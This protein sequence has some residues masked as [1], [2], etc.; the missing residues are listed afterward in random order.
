MLYFS[1]SAHFNQ[2]KTFE[3]L[4]KQTYLTKEYFNRLVEWLFYLILFLIRAEQGHIWLTIFENVSNFLSKRT[5]NKARFG[6]RMANYL[7]H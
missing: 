7:I 2:T 1:W 4:F 5:K 6:P 3:V